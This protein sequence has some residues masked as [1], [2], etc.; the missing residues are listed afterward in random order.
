MSEQPQ[1]LEVQTPDQNCW[2]DAKIISTKPIVLALSNDT[3]V[4]CSARDI[5]ISPGQH[6]YCLPIGTPCW[7]RLKEDWNFG[8]RA[9]ECQVPGEPPNT[10][11]TVTIQNWQE[12]FGSGV[13]PCG[14]KIFCTLERN[15]LLNVFNGDVCQ[16]R[17]ALSSRAGHGYIAYIT[18][19]SESPQMARG[20][21]D[22]I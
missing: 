19:I 13:R 9:I 16:V 11:E 8:W 1:E 20:E 7:V 2:Y 17:I 12:S 15:S 21:V 5:T 6:R 4:S 14:C 22:G 18:A 3:Q 10:T